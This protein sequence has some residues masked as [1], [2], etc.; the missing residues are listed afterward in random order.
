MSAIAR[1][2]VS[3]PGFP[4]D[5]PPPSD[6][7]SGLDAC[8]RSFVDGF[9]LH[10]HPAEPVDARCRRMVRVLQPHAGALPEAAVEVLRDVA[11][12]AEIAVERRLRALLARSICPQAVTWPP[13]DRGY[14]IS[15]VPPATDPAENP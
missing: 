6:A 9:N 15:I 13:L 12:V 8:V 3:E 7:P 5:I 14:Q 11:V 2:A 4:L 1:V 10:A